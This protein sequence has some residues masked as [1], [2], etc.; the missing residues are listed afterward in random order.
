MAKLGLLG[1]S[2]YLVAKGGLSAWASPASHDDCNNGCGLGCSPPTDPFKDPLPIPDELPQRPITDPGFAHLPTPVPNRAINPAT[3]IPFEG[4]TQTHQFRDRFLPQAPN[5]LQPQHLRITR[6][7]PNNNF[8]FSED[9]TNLSRIGP[10]LI[11]GFNKGGDNFTLDPALTPGPTVVARYGTPIVIRRFNQITGSNGGFGV[12]EVSTHLHNFHSG[13]DS[14]GGPCDPT[15]G[16]DT[17][18]PLQ[19]GRFFFGGQYY[20]YFHT[21]ARAGFDTLQYTAPM[22]TSARRS[23][24]CGITTTAWI[25]LP[26][27]STKVWR[28]FSFSSMILTQGMKTP[29]STC[30]AFRSSM[31]R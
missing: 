9:A 10:Q 2:G 30:P 23:P 17:T 6:M 15:T 29:A 1:S 14:D 25:T 8:K 24:R 16:G 4:R 13:P 26:R 20:D 12:P 7:A 11:W 21:M 3:N 22:A 19:Q 28:D 27:T 18:E 5:L 31:S